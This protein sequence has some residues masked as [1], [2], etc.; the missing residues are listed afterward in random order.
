ML[1]GNWCFARSHRARPYGDWRESDRWFAE[2]TTFDAFWQIARHWRFP[3][4]NPPKPA[5]IAYAKAIKEGADPQDIELGAHGYT[6]AMKEAETEPQFIN[7]AAKF[8]AEWRWMQYA[9][10]EIEEREKDKQRE[11]ERQVNAELQAKRDA[12]Y[13]QQAQEKLERFRL[14]K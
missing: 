14:V 2:M 8:L 10:Y 6:R 3:L 13:Q 9:P 12:Y 11:A 1:S 4:P 7:T 5:A